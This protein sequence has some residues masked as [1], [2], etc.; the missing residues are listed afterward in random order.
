MVFKIMVG[1]IK[2]P[3]IAFR[4]RG[5]ERPMLDPH[6]RSA[7]TV[8]S[9]LKY[10]LLIFFEARYISVIRFCSKLILIPNSIRIFKY[11]I[12]LHSSVFRDVL[13]LSG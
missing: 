12:R 4:N 11:A 3:K 8:P 5:E 13:L 1:L 7:V 6:F 2:D 10:D 9:S